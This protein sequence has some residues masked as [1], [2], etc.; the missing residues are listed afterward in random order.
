MAQAA[1]QLA[2]DRGDWDPGAGVGLGAFPGAHPLGRGNAHWHLGRGAHRDPREARDWY[3]TDTTIPPAWRNALETFR[4][5]RARVVVVSG[6]QGSGVSSFLRGYLLPGL[7]GRNF[8]KPV[9]NLRKVIGSHGDSGRVRGL[10][11]KPTRWYNTAGLTPTVSFDHVDALLRS[12]D[13]DAHLD[14]LGR[15]L[16]ECLNNGMNVALCL[17][18]MHRP[19]LL[20]KLE[21]AVQPFGELLEVRIEHPDP[22]SVAQNLTALISRAGVPQRGF[23]DDA[24]QALAYTSGACQDPVWLQLLGRAIVRK[25]TTI[26]M[27]SGKIRLEA[28]S[29]VKDFFDR[30]VARILKE[31]NLTGGESEIRKSIERVLDGGRPDEKTGLVFWALADRWLIRYPRDAEQPFGHPLMRQSFE[32]MAQRHTSQQYNRLLG[33]FAV[34]VAAGTFVMSASRFFH[35]GPPAVVPR[36]SPPTIEKPA[37]IEKALEPSIELGIDVKVPQPAKASKTPHAIP[38]EPVVPDPIIDVES[39]PSNQAPRIEIA[40]PAGRAKDLARLAI[41]ASDGGRTAAAVHLIDKARAALQ[42]GILPSEVANAAAHV[43]RRALLPESVPSNGKNRSFA[44]DQSGQLRFSA[45]LSV[46]ALP[47]EPGLLAGA[48]NALVRIPLDGPERNLPLD[49]AGDVQHVAASKEYVFALGSDGFLRQWTAASLRTGFAAAGQRRHRIGRSVTAFGAG[50]ADKPVIAVISGGRTLQLYDQFVLPGQSVQLPEPANAIAVSPD[51]AHLAIASGEGNI[52]IWTTEPELARVWRLPPETASGP[53]SKLSFLD[54]ASLVIAER[55][56]QI[57]IAVEVTSRKQ[58][59]LARLANL[60]GPI[61]ALAAGFAG[62]PSVALSNNDGIH[63]FPRLPP[64]LLLAQGL[65]ALERPGE[66]KQAWA[67]AASIAD[68]AGPG[69][70]NACDDLPGISALDAELCRQALG[71][72]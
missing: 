29:V 13:S 19:H 20:G 49:S 48:H 38:L 43:I 14:S 4:H 50:G 28:A 53:V 61:K 30:A 44:F 57:S 3:V 16:V 6:P 60:T 7:E 59:P 70:P 64:P 2:F 12:R 69:E 42:P 72:R 51:G 55:S 32:E 47:G 5:G 11:L 56:G 36:D 66:F 1:T 45:Y 37:P 46:A 63:S 10:L 26:Q 25:R 31:L 68:Q 18:G 41:I 40:D 71:T 22:T 52:E 54:S 58:P 23:F 62:R 65:A 39:S 21:G 9:A 15:H 67:L 34:A 27:D 35:S 24:Q 17:N 8:T 33:R